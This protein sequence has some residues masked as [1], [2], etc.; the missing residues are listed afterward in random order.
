[1]YAVV[2]ARRAGDVE[3]KVDRQEYETRARPPVTKNYGHEKADTG[4]LGNV[5]SR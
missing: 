3:E 1:M 2:D 5:D 4:I